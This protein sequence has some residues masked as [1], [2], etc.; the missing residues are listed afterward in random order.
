M[1]HENLVPN[2]LIRVK[3]PP[4]EDSEDEVSSVSPSSARREMAGEELSL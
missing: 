3:L 1:K 2:K 4:R